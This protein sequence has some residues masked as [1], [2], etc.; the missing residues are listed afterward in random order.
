MASIY[1]LCCVNGGLKR[2]KLQTLRQNG[3][4]FGNDRDASRGGAGKSGLL[5]PCSDEEHAEYGD[6]SGRYFCGNQRDC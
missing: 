1:K 3:K 4:G 2:P 5:T 6:D